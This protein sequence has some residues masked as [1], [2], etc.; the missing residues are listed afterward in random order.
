MLRPTLFAML[1]LWAGFQPAVARPAAAISGAQPSQG[2]L[3]LVAEIRPKS[4]E[5]SPM[6]D[7]LAAA[8]LYDGHGQSHAGRIKQV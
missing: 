1:P 3:R 8:V 4:D 5:I 2:E 6:S 7:A